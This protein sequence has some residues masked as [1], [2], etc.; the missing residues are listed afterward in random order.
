MHQVAAAY[1]SD[2]IISKPNGL[3]KE[4]PEAQKRVLRERFADAG[5]ETPRVLDGMDNSEDFYFESIGQVRM[6]RWHKGRI[7][8]VGDAAYCASPLSGMGTALA[9]C[10]A[11]VLAG[12]IN[13]STDHNVAFS[14]YERIMR[15]YVENAQNLPRSIA[16]LGQPQS[17]F[18]IAVQRLILKVG[19][20]PGMSWM[21]GKIFSP[22]ADKIDLPNYG[23]DATE[24][25]A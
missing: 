24:V 9:L 1:L 21:T 13:R 2:R 23:N 4:E 5:W 6:P 22:P 7:A 15:P 11:Y 3:E 19:T 10:G 20:A 12:E 14:E 16:R 25:G 8:V 18:G 17:K